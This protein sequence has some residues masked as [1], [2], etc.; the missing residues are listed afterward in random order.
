MEYPKL[1]ISGLRVS[2]ICLGASQFGARV[3]E[4]T[5]RRIT[6]SAFD[7]GVNF[8]DTADSSESYGNEESERITGKVIGAKREH[9]ILATKVHN[10][11]GTGPENSSLGRRWLMRA[12]DKSLERL[13][14]NY[15]D[16]WYF[17]NDDRDTPIEESLRAVG[18]IIRSGKVRYFGLSNFQAWRVAEVVH[19]CREIGV[20]KP[21]VCQPYYNAIN[22]QCETELLPA[23]A[24]FG[25]GVVTYS[26]LA[27][28]VLTGKYKPGEAPPTDSRAAHKHK[29]FMETEMREDAFVLAQKIKAHAEKRGMTAGQFALNW[30][31]NNRLVTSVLVGPRTEEQWREYLGALQ[32]AINAEDEAL[33]DAMVKPGHP[34]T[35][36]FNDPKFPI[37]GRIPRGLHIPQT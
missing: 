21:V 5:A 33:I 27:R 28:G 25:L 7:A 18:D 24:Y 6:D 14:T 9:W 37:L 3:D 29:R 19:V 34:S 32:H 31:L 36:G 23:C 26:P 10:R 13:N 2:Q 30:V 16:I 15:I 22:R 11:I 17:H 35:P 20:P 4:A 8:I 12:I 1:G